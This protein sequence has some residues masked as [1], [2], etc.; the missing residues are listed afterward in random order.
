M[1]RDDCDL[2]PPSAS[3][4]NPRVQRSRAAITEAARH[5]LLTRGAQAVTV[6]AVLQTSGVARATLYRHFPSANDVLRAAVDA[7]T[8]Q[9]PTTDA[10]SDAY[11]AGA[12][13]AGAEDGPRGTVW[14]EAPDVVRAELLA[15][16]YGVAERL[17]TSEWARVLPDL[18]ALLARDPSLEEYRRDLIDAH[19]LPLVLLLVRARKCALLPED[20]D[21]E[22]VVAAL[23]GPLFYRRLVTGQPL[24]ASL[25]RHVLEGALITPS[26]P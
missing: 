14:E 10:D 17:R 11:S 2:T 22:E 13:L 23:V 6:E 15:Y 21:L 3:A 1:P 18:L 20:R 12:S 24:T 5:L 8:P 4:G 7:I 19:R 25:C 16:L 9:R 26:S